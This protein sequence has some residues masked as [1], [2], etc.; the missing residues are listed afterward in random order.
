MKT[1]IVLLVI[2]LFLFGCKTPQKTT[3]NLKTNQ[4][5]EVKKDVQTTDEQLVAEITNQVISRLTDEKTEINIK[6]TEY[7]TDKPIEPSTGKPP[8]KKESDLKL[9]NQKKVN[10]KETI[11]TEKDSVSQTTSSDNSRIKEKTVGNSKEVVETGLKAW[12]KVLIGVGALTII[13]L[14]VFLIIKFI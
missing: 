6:T 4:E 10:E 13:G 7:D 5:T 9:N 3:S 2:T 11:E 1:K 12:Q 14:V 8:V